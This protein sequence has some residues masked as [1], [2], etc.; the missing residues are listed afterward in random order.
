M[1]NQH[2]TDWYGIRANW[3]AGKRE[4][5]DENSEPD[6]W[7]RSATGKMRL[8]VKTSSSNVHSELV[9]SVG[10]SSKGL[11]WIELQLNLVRP[12][13]TGWNV[14]GELFSCSDDQTIHKWNP[15]GEPEGK[16]SRA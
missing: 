13:P 16:A 8:K 15:L 4:R 5:L 6:L 9:G 12:I 2:G 3:A 7:R 10:A 1:L 14:W 11:D